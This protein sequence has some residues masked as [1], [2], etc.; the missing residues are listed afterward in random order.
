MSESLPRFIVEVNSSDIALFQILCVHRFLSV[1]FSWKNT[2]CKDRRF[3]GLLI[4][5]INSR[6]KH[7]PSLIC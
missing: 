5:N 4:Y 3:L 2:F 7:V 6:Y 1:F